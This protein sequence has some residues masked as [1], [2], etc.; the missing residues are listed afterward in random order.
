MRR[1]FPAVENL[2]RLLLTSS[3][4]SCEAERSLSAL[5]RLKTWLRSTMTQTRLNHMAICHVH[6][7]ILMEISSQD[8]ER[9]NDVRCSVFGK[10]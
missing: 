5:C 2:L 4:S 1:L 10:F 3:A 7:D 6:R 8:I 9:A